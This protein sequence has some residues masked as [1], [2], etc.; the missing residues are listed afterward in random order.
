MDAPLDGTHTRGMKGLPYDWQALLIP[1]E[2]VFSE[3]LD[4]LLDAT[5]TGELTADAGL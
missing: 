5:L 1:V 4:A 3:E 2:P